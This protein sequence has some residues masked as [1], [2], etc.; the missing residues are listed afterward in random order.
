[1]HKYLGPYIPILKLNT[2]DGNVDV[3]NSIAC[4]NWTPIFEWN[5]VF[6]GAKNGN[7]KDMR[8]KGIGLHVEHDGKLTIQGS[9]TI[10]K[11]YT[12]VLG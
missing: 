5:L 12:V 6:C 1:M 11:T 7:Q 10:R 4:V 9:N 2:K 8:V 3:P